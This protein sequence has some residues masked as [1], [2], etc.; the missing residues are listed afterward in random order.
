M[1]KFGRFRPADFSLCVP[2]AA[3]FQ[4]GLDPAV[5]QLC[6]CRGSKDQEKWPGFDFNEIAMLCQCCAGEL[7][8]SGSRWSGFFCEA[9]HARVVGLNKTVG[10]TVI[11]VGRHTFMSGVM[12]RPY[13]AVS[14]V[15]DDPEIPDGINRFVK[16][17]F[18]LKGMIEHLEAWHR[19]AVRSNLE[20]IGLESRDVV[21]LPDYLRR[22]RAVWK[23]TPGLADEVMFGRM[24]RHFCGDTDDGSAA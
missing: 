9:C 5:L 15:E 7:V 12:L 8:K 11:P 1:P 16:A 24:Y 14:E 13:S 4:E 18:L 19:R 23:K 17:I 6:R 20:A 3:L 22:L 10:G 21:S 2:C